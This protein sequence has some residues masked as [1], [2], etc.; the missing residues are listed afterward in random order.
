MSQAQGLYTHTPE[1]VVNFEIKTIGLNITLDKEDAKIWIPLIISY[2]SISYN[3]TTSSV[4]TIYLMIGY[5]ML[6]FFLEGFIS[7]VKTTL[8]KLYDWYMLH[9]PECKSRQIICVGQYPITKT[10]FEDTSNPFTYGET[11][12]PNINICAER[13][14]HKTYKCCKCG[15]ELAKGDFGV[16]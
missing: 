2:W 4:T 11:G 3:N 12:I 5:Y 1:A 8:K 6:V 15:K 13:E 9:C 10:K 16:F 7:K 14:L